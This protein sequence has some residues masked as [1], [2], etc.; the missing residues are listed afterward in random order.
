MLVSDEGE[1]A[2]AVEMLGAI[3]RPAAATATVAERHDI[4]VTLRF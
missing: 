2:R 3:D 4:A 1:M